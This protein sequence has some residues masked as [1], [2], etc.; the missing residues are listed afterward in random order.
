MH[1]AG[2]RGHDQGSRLHARLTPV[3]V[4]CGQLACWRVI[5]HHDE[6]RDA[7]QL[8]RQGQ[9]SSVVARAAGIAKIDTAA[10]RGR[11]CIKQWPD[12]AAACARS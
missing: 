11:G 4:D 5:G 10:Q 3:L 12:P 1:S 8:G 6:G 7:S 2:G 9:R